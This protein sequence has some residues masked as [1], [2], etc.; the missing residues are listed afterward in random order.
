MDYLVNIQGFAAD[1]YG[2]GAYGA[3][4][5]MCT[6]SA[7]GCQQASTAASGSLV[8]G[9]VAITGTIAFACLIIFAALLVRFWRRKNTYKISGRA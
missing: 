8:N 9:G 2:Q 6:Q 3:D 1:V 7:A 4:P 5:Y